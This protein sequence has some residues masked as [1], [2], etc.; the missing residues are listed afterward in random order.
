MFLELAFKSQLR[1][2][3]QQ[4]CELVFSFE[5][6]EEQWELLISPFVV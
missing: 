2:Q 6:L 3:V 1:K 5:Y 4:V